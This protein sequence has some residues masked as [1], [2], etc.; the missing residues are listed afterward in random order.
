MDVCPTDSDSLTRA[1]RHRW[2]IFSLLAFGYI[3][4]YFHRLCPAVLAIDMMRDL[5][6]G[7]ALIG[8]LGSAY[9]YPYALM[10]LPAGVLSDSWGPRKTV[11][12]F[13]S[14]AFLGSI[15]LGLSPSLFWAIFGR[16]LVGLGISMLFVPTLKVLA[17]WFSVREFAIM[18]GIFLAMGGLGSL[19]AAAPL[20]LLSNWLGWRFSFVAV[21]ILTLILAVLVWLLVRD[22]PAD[23]GWSSPSEQ[24]EQGAVSIPLL[25]GIREV[26][27]CP[28]FWPVAIW[29]FFTFAVFFSFAGLWGGP[30]LMQVYGFSKAQAGRILSMLS[31]GMI[32]GSPLLGFF[33]NRVFRGRKRLLIISSSFLLGLTLLLASYTEKLTPVIL[34]LICLGLGVFAFAVSSIAYTATKELFPIQIAGTSTGLVNLFPF[35]GGAIFQPLL[36]YIVERKGLLDGAFTVAGYR[37]AFLVLFLCSFF[38]FL[39]TLFVRETIE[40]TER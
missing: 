16:I 33:S 30:Y 22:R 6:V 21:G 14:I 4:V 23:L 19:T 8:L 7:G 34:Y 35:A 24:T 5:R 1:L 9:F 3:L 36:G 31:V 28:S 12:L 10:Q 25:R 13:F 17:E 26:L 20:A 37:Q 38:A 15:I 11:A 18:T 27:A 2:I 29:F 32:A 39:A 40:A